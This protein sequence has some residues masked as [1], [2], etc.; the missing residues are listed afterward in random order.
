MT[1]RKAAI[2]D[3]RILEKAIVSNTEITKNYKA[4]REKAEKFGKIFLLRN[5][6]F[7]AVLFSVAEYKRLSQI[8]EYLEC[9]EDRDAEVFM[10]SLPRIEA[11]LVLQ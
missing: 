8:I 3:M 7:D 2:I 9:L 1:E 4:C 10:K 5:N 11:K 6:Q